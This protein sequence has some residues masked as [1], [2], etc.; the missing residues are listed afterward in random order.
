MM[1]SSWCF[2]FAV[3]LFAMFILTHAIEVNSKSVKNTASD[4]HD[5]PVIRSK[6]EKLGLQRKL[7]GLNA[8]RRSGRPQNVRIVIQS[9][10]EKPEV[11]SLTPVRLEVGPGDKRRRTHLRKKSP[12][13]GYRELERH[14]TKAVNGRE[15]ELAVKEQEVST[16]QMTPLKEGDDSDKNMVFTIG[17][18]LLDHDVDKAV[19]HKADTQQQPSKNT[20]RLQTR[21]SSSG[22]KMT[23]SKKAAGCDHH[24]DCVPGSC[25]NLRKH[26]C[27]PH[28]RGLNNKCYDDC[29]CEEGLR[30]FAKFH[31]NHRVIHKKGRCVDPE[32][33]NNVHAPSYT[34]V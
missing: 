29:M 14:K 25:C 27:E 7:D 5:N 34:A 30:C 9:Q 28:S 17:M 13:S 19:I 8:V 22:K 18:A 4:Q 33:L 26:L 15:P 23:P 10:Y 6:S 20:G 3:L 12:Q 1:S 2:G 16:V 31:H 11:E 32:F 24:L 21:S